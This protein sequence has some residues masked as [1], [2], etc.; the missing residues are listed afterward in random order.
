MKIQA[1]TGSQRRRTGVGLRGNAFQPFRERVGGDIGGHVVL[2]SLSDCRVDCVNE[3]V[4]GASPQPPPRWARAQ[5]CP[6]GR[7]RPRACDCLNQQRSTSD[8]PI[9]S[10][11]GLARRLTIGHRARI[12]G[13][14]GA[15]DHD[16]GRPPVPT[17]DMVKQF[18][19]RP[20]WARG[21]HSRRVAGANQRTKR[22]GLIQQDRTV[23]H[24][25]TIADTTERNRLP[26]GSKTRPLVA[27]AVLRD[28]CRCA[29]QNVCTATM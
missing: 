26:A 10:T 23:I 8:E 15:R 25:A 22:A 20:A 28:G 16:L 11:S 5:D 13:R 7:V 29:C 27:G 19:H 4:K 17:P 9:K 1:L 3:R 21:D 14:I 24:T 2:H 6:H 18:V 12:G